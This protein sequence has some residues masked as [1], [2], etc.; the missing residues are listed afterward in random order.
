[1][2]DCRQESYSLRIRR[3]GTA[4]C[5]HESGQRITIDS[6]PQQPRF[7]TATNYRNTPS[8]P[9]KSPSTPC[10]SYSQ[11]PTQ[12][13]GTKRVGAHPTSKCSCVP[14]P[15]RPVSLPENSRWA[16]ID[17]TGRVV[18]LPPG[19]IPAPCYHMYHCPTSRKRQELPKKDETYIYQGM[20][21][22]SI[23][24]VLHLLSLHPKKDK[25]G[26]Y[27]NHKM[28][29]PMSPS[30]ARS[31]SFDQ[32]NKQTK[33]KH[34]ARNNTASRR[35]SQLKVEKAECTK[36]PASTQCSSTKK[37]PPKEE[38]RKK[39]MYSFEEFLKWCDEADDDHFNELRQSSFS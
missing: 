2:E 35:I 17:A 39:S 15:L 22:R 8:V 20:E 13:S 28:V 32:H 38:S 29:T 9:G 19:C 1:M 24:N 16:I 3:N 7:R 36:H 4:H 10:K 21:L 25:N 11:Y 37:S 34:S 18:P 23:N 14:A 26:N 6:F 30:V 33:G 12:Y 27:L 31:S 5:A